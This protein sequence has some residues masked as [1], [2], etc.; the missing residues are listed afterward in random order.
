MQDSGCS[1]KYLLISL[2]LIPKV[3]DVPQG[4]AGSPSGMLGYGVAEAGPGSPT[5]IPESSW[6]GGRMQCG[7][8]PH[9][10]R[11]PANTTPQA[12]GGDNVH[13]GRM[14]LFIFLIIL[15]CLALNNRSSSGFR[16]YHLIPVPCST[17]FVKLHQAFELYP[18]NFFLTSELK[19]FMKYS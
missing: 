18:S 5:S 7:F 4:A 3:C 8:P 6:L 16:L 9:V 15:A 11:A 14:Q 10:P 19:F 13:M 2:L 12:E 17:A 1:Q